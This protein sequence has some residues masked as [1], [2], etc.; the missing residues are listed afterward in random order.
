MHSSKQSDFERDSEGQTSMV[1][2]AFEDKKKH[3]RKCFRRKNEACSSSDFERS[4]ASKHARAMISSAQWPRRKKKYARALI[5]RAQWPSGA[6]KSKLD[7]R[8]RAPS[9]QK[10]SSSSGFER[11]VAT[12]HARAV[13]LSVQS[14][15]LRLCCVFQCCRAV[16]AFNA[17][18]FSRQAGD[19]SGKPNI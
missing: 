19:L 7:Q 1:E 2:S 8:F 14:K 3:A 6:T 11:P 15:K 10:A 17:F 16:K 4:V 5:S 18:N 9:G 13:I 12:E